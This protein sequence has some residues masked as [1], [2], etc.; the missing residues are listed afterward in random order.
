[1]HISSAVNVETFHRLIRNAPFGIYFIN[2]DYTIVEASR[3]AHEAFASVVPLIGCDVRTAL[4]TIWQEPF[5]SLAIDAFARTLR[6]GEPYISGEMVEPRAD[7]PVTEA[8]DWRL[9]RIVMPDDRYGVVCY[10][11]DL[12][13]RLRAEQALADSETMF[14]QF[15]DNSTDALWV[16][17]AST[18]RLEYVSRAF[19][20]IWGEPVRHV[21]M[22]PGRWNDLVHPD[23]RAAVRELI[24]RISAGETVILTYRIAR[25]DTGELRW[26]HETGFPIYDTSGQVVR[27]G[28][29]AQDMTDRIRA[30]S[31]VQESRQVLDALLQGIPQLVWRSGDN[32]K[33]VWVSRQW[34]TYTGQY[35]DQGLGH[36]WLE[37]VH[38]DDRCMVMKD[39]QH[40]SEDRGL[41]LRLRLRHRMGE[42]RWFQ[43]RAS[44][45]L[46]SEGRI[47]E[48]LGTCTDVDDLQRL[49]EKQEV[50]VEELQHRTRNLLGV[51]RSMA[52]QTRA[53]SR[54]LDDFG[55]RFNNRLNALSRVQG[56]L[57][58]SQ[59]TAITIS[60][61][62]S[63]ELE[64]FGAHLFGKRVK[65]EG[66]P[67]P[68]RARHVQTLALALHELATNARKYGALAHDD[69]ELAIGW[70]A[71][72]A[73]SGYSFLRIDWEETGFVPF[74]KEQP[75]G[76]G[77]YGR[78]LIERALPYS[79]GARTSYQLDS[80]GVRCSIELPLIDG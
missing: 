24:P 43:M 23:D 61:L 73:G 54:S 31:A 66:P 27:A 63:A 17:N 59:R 70:S 34:Q 38:P 45:F 68:L 28:G 11:Y 32:G 6:T 14:R 57:S 53:S 60:D 33:W 9:E 58:R 71:G 20:K 21:L 18:G 40:A 4:S 48:W 30:Q 79:L 76:T 51:V 74:L 52:T 2:A 55:E 46:D 8:Y 72:K 15:A 12:T 37:A 39:W 47:L 50:M 42:Y 19:S 5:A 69:G 80:K 16:A 7:L 1:L 44:A 35:E 75:V 29:I 22:E 56:L 10:F 67:V 26:I 3:N 65:V 25:A 36:G 77:G 64:A 62:V 49:Q 41:D 13:E 78:K